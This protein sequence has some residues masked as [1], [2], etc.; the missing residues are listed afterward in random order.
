MKHTLCAISLAAVV[1]GGCSQANP[2]QQTVNDAAAALGGSDRVQAVRTV[3]IEGTGTQWNLGQDLTPTATGQTF[4]IANYRRAIDVAGGRARTELT[5]SPN[6]P[7]FAGQAAQ[8]QVQ[9]FDG[10]VAYNVA[11]N[12]TATRAAT[13]V[14]TDRRTEIYHHPITAVR[15]ALDPMSTVTNRRS[16]GGETLVDVKT[17]NGVTFTLA[18]D[19]SALPTRVMS[20]TDNTNLGDVTIET[21]FADYQDVNGLKLPSRMTTKTDNV[22]TAEIRAAKQ[23]VDGDTGDLAAPAA[24]ASAPALAGPPPAMVTAQELANGIWYLAGQSHH[25]VLVEFSDHLM[26]IETPQNDVRALAV[27]AKARELRPG[28]PLTQ[29]VNSHHHFDHSGG[30]RAAMS[31]GLTVIAHRNAAEYLEDAGKRPHTVTPDALAK[32]AKPPTIEAVEGERTIS[33]GTMTVN[34]F[35]VEGSAHADSMLMAYFPRERLLVEADVFTPGA[36]VHPYAANLL[37]NIRKHNLRVDRIVPLHGTVAPFAELE[38][39]ALAARA[40]TA[41]N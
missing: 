4:T 26:L 19:G 31:E 28:K 14:A 17:A 29:V 9:G 5:R 36:P 21:S 38:K 30:I 22:T 34:L 24:A 33:D 10:E 16:E 25:S 8:K 2:E 3:V 40:Q 12:G 37:E 35:A 7:F 11:A 41:T 23:S 27:I 6:F 1:I 39:A 13:P 32:N 15:A 18:V 20:K